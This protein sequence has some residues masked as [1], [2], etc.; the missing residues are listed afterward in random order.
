MLAVVH[1]SGVD[2]P[3]KLSD[4][5]RPRRP[6]RWHGDLDSFYDPDHLLYFDEAID[7]LDGRQTGLRCAAL[8]PRAL[9]ARR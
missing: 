7:H 5:G 4:R 1:P 9:A 6:V 2:L 8:L 3:C